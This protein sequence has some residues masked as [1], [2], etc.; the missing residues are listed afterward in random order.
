MNHISNEGYLR[1]PQVLELLPVAKSKFYSGVK[2][3][4]YPKPVK[5]GKRISAWRVSE[6]RELLAK[7][8]EQK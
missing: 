4:I 2:A 6:I 5:I 3:G 7:I 8:S 1:L